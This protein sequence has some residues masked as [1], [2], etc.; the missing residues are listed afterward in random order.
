MREIE[1]APH[2]LLA[3]DAM[4]KDLALEPQAV[5]N[6]ALVAWLRANGYAVPPAA[7][8]VKRV[9]GPV[10]APPLVTPVVPPV[11]PHASRASPVPLAVA[12]V[13]ATGAL[14]SPPSRSNLPKVETKAPSKTDLPPVVDAPP[15]PVVVEKAEA[16][17]PPAPPANVPVSSPSQVAMRDEALARLKEISAD[18]QALTRPWPDWVKAEDEEEEE[19]EDDEQGEDEQVDDDEQPDDEQADDEP[20]G[21]DAQD[22]APAEEEEENPFDDRQ[23]TRAAGPTPQ[24]RGGAEDEDEDAFRPTAVRDSNTGENEV[25]PPAD[26]TVV[27]RSVPIVLYLEREGEEPVRVDVERF[28]IGRGPQCDLVIDSP[29]VS[30]EHAVLTRSGIRYVLEDQN[31]SN[32]TWMGEER[33]SRRE[34]ESGDVISLGNEA[35]TFILRGE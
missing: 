24:A 5:V 19:D 32:G 11:V 10:A 2:L 16:T 25:E 31:S 29:R 1:L 20:P 34:I 18:L 7:A 27:L 12:P 35:I 8:A 13:P 14:A 21:D 4:A 15:K 17:E 28:V 6:Q 26:S 23:P 22:E 3:L 9:D 30:R 33:V